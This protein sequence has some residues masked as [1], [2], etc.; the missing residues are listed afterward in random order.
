M[1]ACTEHTVSNLSGFVLSVPRKAA[2]NKHTTLFDIHPLRD[3]KRTS[4]FG[5]W[6]GNLS[7]WGV[8]GHRIEL[9]SDFSILEDP[10]AL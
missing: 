7:L 2:E 1:S 8:F 3:P 10:S 9:L 4:I 5:N 6:K